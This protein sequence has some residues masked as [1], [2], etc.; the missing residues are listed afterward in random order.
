MNF[1]QHKLLYYEIDASL[2]HGQPWEVMSQ[3]LLTRVDEFYAR[4]VVMQRCLGL[5]ALPAAHGTGASGGGGGGGGAPTG[6]S[7]VTAAG[8]TRSRPGSTAGLR[9]GEAGTV[10]S[11]LLSRA[12]LDSARSGPHDRFNP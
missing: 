5:G 4:A 1:P 6:T 7:D 12:R 11:E 9:A 8:V 2:R 3:P 10:G